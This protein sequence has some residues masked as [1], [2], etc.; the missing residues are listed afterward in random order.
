MTAR[1]ESQRTAIW[2][3]G[4]AAV[5]IATTVVVLHWQSLPV[6]GN[7]SAK[8]RIAADPPPRLFAAKTV[9]PLAK[10]L[11]GQQAD[12]RRRMAPWWKD[13][14]HRRHDKAFVVWLAKHAPQPPKSADRAHE[15][16]TLEALASHRTEGGVQAATWLERNGKKDIWKL[17]AHDQA[18]WLKTDKGEA[19]KD[20]IKAALKMAKHVSDEVAARYKQSSPYVTERA[21]LDPRSTD[22]DPVKK[23]KSEKRPCPCS[24]PAGHATKAAAARTILS[25]TAPA[26]SA[27]YRWMESEI[28]YSRL[29]M[30][31]HFKSDIV[32]G[33]LLGDMIGLYINEA[34]GDDPLW[35]PS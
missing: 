14:G 35:P 17:Y 16:Q 11:T 10:D 20:D 5:L 1:A 13:H 29:Y 24:Y 23:L 32:A 27:E 26:R 15:M 31:G 12:A 4:I 30:G 8:D 19:E 18:E 33:T 22:Q 25:S 21:L 2:V 9:S 7:G 6:V 3:V 34:R 28:D